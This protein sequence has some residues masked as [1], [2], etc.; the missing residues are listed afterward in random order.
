MKIREFLSTSPGPSIAPTLVRVDEWLTAV[1]AG[2]SLRPSD[3]A[4]G[5][6]VEH[7]G[8]SLIAKASGPERKLL[9]K[10]L[11]EA[12]Y[13]SVG[14][15]TEVDSV[16]LKTRLSQYLNRSGTHA[17]IR[18][19]LSLFFFNFVRFETG[20]SFRRLATSS[21]AFE[22]YLEDIDR[23]CHQ[24]VASVWKSFE[25]TKRPLDL[26]A[27]TDLVSQVDRRLRGN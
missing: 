21:K 10:S 4:K 18:L 15:D 16:Q 6:P 7:T 20:E 22:E 12:L 24:T 3:R 2:K 5:D 26:T 19:F 9:S 1:Q 25:K 13:Y 23:A 8:E 11:Q 14:F 17:F 27:A